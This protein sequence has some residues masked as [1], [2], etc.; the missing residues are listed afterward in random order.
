MAESVPTKAILSWLSADGWEIKSL[1]DRETGN[2]R[3][4]SILQDRCRKGLW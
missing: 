1:A 3:P 2:D 4:L